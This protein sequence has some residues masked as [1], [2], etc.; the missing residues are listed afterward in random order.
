LFVRSAE[1]GIISQLIEGRFGHSYPF[2]K[3]DVGQLRCGRW[4]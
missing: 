1:L 2:S 3:F 4:H